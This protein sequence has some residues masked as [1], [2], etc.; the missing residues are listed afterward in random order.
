M[1]NNFTQGRRGGREGQGMT[2]FALFV[3]IAACLALMCALGYRSGSRRGK[4]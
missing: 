4:E 1:V 2:D 3:L